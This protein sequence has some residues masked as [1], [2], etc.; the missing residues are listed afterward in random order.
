MNPLKGQ[1]PGTIIG[2]FV[3]AVII[4][5]ATTGMN[6]NPNSPLV[7]STYGLA[8]PGICLAHYSTSLQDTL[9]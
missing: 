8:L 2:G 3:L 7:G 6:F 5:A 4:A 1:W 9:H